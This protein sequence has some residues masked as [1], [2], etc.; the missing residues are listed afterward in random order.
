FGRRFIS[1]VQ[2]HR[3]SDQ[4]ALAEI[5]T[6][7]VFLADDAVKIGLVD[8]IGYLSDAV[9]EAE[10]LAGLS[11]DAKLVTYRRTEFPDDNVYNTAGIESETP[12][13]SPINI[14]IPESLYPNAGFYYLWSAAIGD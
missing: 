6:A 7:R 4:S 8:K 13:T 9:K 11:E 2:T 14:E 10:K 1:L 5:S 3:K 12:N